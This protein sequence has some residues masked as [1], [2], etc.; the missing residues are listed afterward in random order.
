MF[1]KKGDA[2]V[3]AKLNEAPEQYR[4][5]GER[6][7]SIIRE[8]APSLEP[9]VRWGLPFYVKDGVDIC[10][11]K[12]GKDF[13]AFG[14][15]EAVNPAREGGANMHPVAWN[16]TALDDATEANIGALVEKAVA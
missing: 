9:I 13:I 7:H 14:F 1:T 10:Y 6:L 8:S 2:A 3:L 4:E 15:G 16:I 11:I 5:I 12:P